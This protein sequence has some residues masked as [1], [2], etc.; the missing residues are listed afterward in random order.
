LVGLVFA[1]IVVELLYVLI[2]HVQHWWLA[3]WLCFWS[4]CFAAATRPVVLFPIFTNS[5]RWKM[6]NCGGDWFC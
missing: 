2:R 5:N 3:A 4:V 1:T 6:R